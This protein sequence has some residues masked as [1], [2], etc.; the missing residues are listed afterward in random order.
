MALYSVRLDVSGT[1]RGTVDV[2]VTADS[3]EQVH[4]WGDLG[5]NPK[6]E[7]LLREAIVEQGLM[8]IDISEVKKIT[9]VGKILDEARGK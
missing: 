8:N 2:F 4:E 1:V 6:F 7:K 9:D 3:K 5:E